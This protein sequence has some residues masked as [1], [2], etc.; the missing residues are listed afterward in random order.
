[1]TEM[2]PDEI[3]YFTDNRQALHFEQVFRAAR[4]GGLVKAGDGPCSFPVRNRQRKGRQAVQNPRGRHNAAQRPDRHD[5]R[6]GRSATFRRREGYRS[7]CRAQSRLCRHE[8]RRSDVQTAA[9]TIPSI[10]RNSCNSTAKPAH[11]CCI[12]MSAFSRCSPSWAVM[13]ISTPPT[14]ASG[15][16]LRAIS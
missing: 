12:P 13:R 14:S 1:M 9:G 2:N 8:V 4:K 15:R 7:G 3:W 5:H 11:T 6:R 16:S 10:W